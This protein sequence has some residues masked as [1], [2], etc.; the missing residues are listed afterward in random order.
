MSCGQTPILQG[1]GQRFGCNM[2]S[3]ITHRG[4]LNFMVFNKR[5]R[6]DEFLDFLKGNDKDR[7][8]L[9]TQPPK[10]TPHC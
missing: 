6:A 3:A 7:S 8:W 5:F 2:I 4:R 1:T 10:N 9:F